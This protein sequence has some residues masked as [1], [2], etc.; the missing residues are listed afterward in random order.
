MKKII[1]LLVLLTITSYAYT[2][3][4]NIPTDYSTIQ[5]GIDAASDYDTVLVDTG[6]YVENIILT[7]KILLLLQNF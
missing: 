4:I 6:T 3:T 2:T 7:V 1:S 5:A